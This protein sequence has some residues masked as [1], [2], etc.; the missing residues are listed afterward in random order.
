MGGPQVTFSP[1]TFPESRINA[2][3][4][5]QSQYAFGDFL[6]KVK[7][8]GSFDSV[9]N[10]IAKNRTNPVRPLIGNPDKL[11]PADRDLVISGSFLRAVAKKTFY[12]SNPC[13]HRYNIRNRIFKL[14]EDYQRGPRL[15]K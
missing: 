14:P 4:V 7:E 15:W 9:E 5:G 12:A 11:P 1:E 8:G 2:Y 13:V 10:L 3:C 6:V